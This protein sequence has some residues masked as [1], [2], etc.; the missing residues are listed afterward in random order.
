M[1]LKGGPDPR[2]FQSISF[3]G[4]CRLNSGTPNLLYRRFRLSKYIS[5]YMV[6]C[7][8]KLKVREPHSIVLRAVLE[9]Q[10]VLIGRDEFLAG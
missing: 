6:I 7:K 4:I 9:V 8:E 2:N 10:L 3:L 5:I 1:S